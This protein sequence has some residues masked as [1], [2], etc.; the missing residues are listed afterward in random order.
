MK[1]VWSQASTSQ[2]RPKNLLL[3]AVVCIFLG[4]ILAGRPG[5]QDAPKPLRAAIASLLGTGG[6]LFIVGGAA[7]AFQKGKR[8]KPSLWL[9]RPADPD[10]PGDPMTRF[11]E[12]ERR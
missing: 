11:R 1:L 6:L 7:L 4:G 2:D 3:L 12:E 5:L 8:P 9:A 10:T